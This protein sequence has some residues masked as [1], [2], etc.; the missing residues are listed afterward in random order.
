MGIIIIIYQITQIWIYS[1]PYRVYLLLHIF[2]SVKKTI[3]S[4]YESLC[5]FS[6]RKY[7]QNPNKSPDISIT[8]AKVMAS[9][10]KNGYFLE[11]L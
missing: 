11:S 10:V 9:N 3:Q 2:P 8:Q 7:Q 1:K 5:I 6:R 4:E